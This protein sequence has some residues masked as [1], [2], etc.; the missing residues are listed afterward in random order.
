MCGIAR[1]LRR[2]SNNHLQ[3]MW[4][5]IEPNSRYVRQQTDGEGGSP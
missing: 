3:P 4:D 2:P 1:K 5:V